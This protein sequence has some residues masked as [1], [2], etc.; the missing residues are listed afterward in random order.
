MRLDRIKADTNLTRGRRSDW[1][2]DSRLW[3]GGV[4]EGEGAFAGGAVASHQSGARCSS[5]TVRC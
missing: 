1:R 5:G 3:G 2:F 4:G